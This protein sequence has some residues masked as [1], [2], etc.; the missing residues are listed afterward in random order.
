MK[1]LKIE[2]YNKLFNVHEHICPKCYGK[3]IYL[4]DDGFLCNECHHHTH[5]VFIPFN[6]EEYIK[7][8]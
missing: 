6:I 8:E 5:M 7:K 2:T 4:L 1:I 3:N